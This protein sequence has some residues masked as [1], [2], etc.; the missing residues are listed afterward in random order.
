[1]KTLREYE[2]E[3]IEYFRE[4]GE[5]I[6]VA[7]ALGS[8]ESKRDLDITINSMIMLDMIKEIKGLNAVDSE[9]VEVKQAV[10]KK[11]TK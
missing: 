5:P 3:A 10:N 7:G 2:L 6:P 9:S 1:M 11:V 4:I 8:G